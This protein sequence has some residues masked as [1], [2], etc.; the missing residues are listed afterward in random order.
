MRPAR[1]LLTIPVVLELAVGVGAASAQQAVPTAPTVGRTSLVEVGKNRDGGTVYIAR[2]YASTNAGVVSLGGAAGGDFSFRVGGY[3]LAASEASVVPTGISASTTAWSYNVTQIKVD[4][5]K[6]PASQACNY[7]VRVSFALSITGAL[8]I[9]QVEY[10][11]YLW[12]SG[13]VADPGVLKVIP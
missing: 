4:L 11:V 7:T 3:C 9:S 10:T 13:G 6:D 2:G 8:T 5:V 1:G 12:G